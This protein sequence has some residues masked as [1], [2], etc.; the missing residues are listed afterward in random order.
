[1]CCIFSK[2]DW[3]NGFT[4]QVLPSYFPYNFANGL[5]I[6]IRTFQKTDFKSE[7]VPVEIDLAIQNN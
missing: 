4:S 5:L 7:A 6:V 2:V 1:M 3:D